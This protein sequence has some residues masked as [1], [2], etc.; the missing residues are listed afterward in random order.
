MRNGT[1]DR[2]GTFDLPLAIQTLAGNI[3][4]VRIYRVIATKHY[5]VEILD[6]QGRVR[7]CTYKMPTYKDALQTFNE[8]IE[9]LMADL[10]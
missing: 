3:G 2:I 4:T 6:M 1:V 8:T 5:N 9:M 7:G 10:P